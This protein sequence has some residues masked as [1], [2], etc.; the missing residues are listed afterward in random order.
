MLSRF[1]SLAAIALFTYATPCLSAPQTADR[2]GTDFVQQDKKDAKDVI[3]TGE[4]TVWPKRVTN[5]LNVSGLPSGTLVEITTL[6]GVLFKKA[7]AGND[8]FLQIDMTDAEPGAYIVK[9]GEQQVKI[10]KR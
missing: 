9:A 4:L 8:G 6:S 3:R 10:Y 5:Y 7:V 2:A 1:I